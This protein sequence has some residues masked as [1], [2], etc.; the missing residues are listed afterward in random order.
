MAT[1]EQIGVVFQIVQN[2]YGLVADM[3]DNA[4]S[5][6]GKA[7]DS[8]IAAIMAA[9]ANQY[10]RRINWMTDLGTR[11]LPVLT[12]ALAIFGQTPSAANTFAQNLLAVANHT[13]AAS[14]QSAADVTTEANYILANVP[15]YERLW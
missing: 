1:F 2:L 12:A 7:S 5:Y 8:N 15:N 14:L 6:I 13:K 4:Q 9:D 3:R 10:V 11:N